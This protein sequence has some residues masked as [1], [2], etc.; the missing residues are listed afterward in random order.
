MPKMI[1]ILSCSKRVISFFLFSSFFVLPGIVT[2]SESYR[3]FVVSSKFYLGKVDDKYISGGKKILTEEFSR[4][5]NLEGEA[6]L[7]KLFDSALN[8]EVPKPKQKTFIDCK[9]KCLESIREIL[10]EENLQAVVLLTIAQKDRKVRLQLLLTDDQ[11]TR[12]ESSFC[13]NCNNSKFKTVLLQLV[14][15]TFDYNQTSLKTGENPDQALVKKTPEPKPAT[16]AVRKKKKNISAEAFYGWGSFAESSSSVLGLQSY[17]KNLGGGLTNWDFQFKTS[18]FDLKMNT[19]ALNFGYQFEMRRNLLPF[20]DQ[21]EEAVGVALG[22]VASGNASFGYSGETYK[23]SGPSGFDVMLTFGKTFHDWKGFLG[24]M[25]HNRSL[26]NL[27]SS[28]NTK[29]KDQNFSWINL[30]FGGGW[31]F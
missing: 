13:D 27:S 9:A 19:L 15:K 12:I 10:R 29:I 1:T 31:I 26:T 5:S 4:R 22:W 11:K 17:W 14:Q 18:S 21:G 28:N 2:A 16:P 25:Y 6:H 3:I 23:S 7:E 24:F 8:P 20:G 30:V